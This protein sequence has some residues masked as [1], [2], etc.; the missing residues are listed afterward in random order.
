VRAAY[1]DARG[2]GIVHIDGRQSKQAVLD[3]AWRE[4]LAVTALS[5]RGVS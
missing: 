1:R 4:V 2:P 3:A 5:T